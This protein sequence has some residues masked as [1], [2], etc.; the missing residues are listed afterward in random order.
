MILTIRV[1]SLGEMPSD[2]LAIRLRPILDLNTLS[3]VTLV[4]FFSGSLV[5]GIQGSLV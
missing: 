3:V 4:D 2:A 5:L 1:D